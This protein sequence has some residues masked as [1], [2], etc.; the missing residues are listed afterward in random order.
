MEESMKFHLPVFCLLF[1]GACTSMPPVIKDFSAVDIPYQL[2]SQDI[3]SYQ[4]APIRWGGK[5]INVENETDISLVQVL[6]YP[7]DRNGYPQTN[8]VSEGR[9]A[10]ETSDFLDPAIF[11]VETIITVVGTVKGEID[12]IV[13]KKNIRIPLVSAEAMHLWREDYRG[14]RYYGEAMH[15]YV[16]EPYFGGY[17]GSYWCWW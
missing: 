16:P 17:C 1:L 5:I 10:I 6:F 7:L 2:I 4:D 8:E 11:T 3:N 14:D 13:G 12:R 15:R 9:F